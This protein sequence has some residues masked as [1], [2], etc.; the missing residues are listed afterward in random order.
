MLILNIQEIIKFTFHSYIPDKCM[1]KVFFFFNLEFYIK[2][3]FFYGWAKFTET[4]L[5]KALSKFIL[6]KKLIIKF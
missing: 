3:F 6:P 2:K 4:N 1:D 5:D